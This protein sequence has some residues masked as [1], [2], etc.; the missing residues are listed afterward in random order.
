MD[1]FVF[2]CRSSS[3][4]RHEL[5]SEVACAAFSLDRLHPF[6]ILAIALL[7]WDDTSFGRGAPPATFASLI[8]WSYRPAGGGS[9]DPPTRARR[10][11][12]VREIEMAIPMTTSI[13]KKITIIFTISMT[14][15]VG[16]IKIA[17]K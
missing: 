5:G 17:I 9:G 16:A 12:V 13:R 10:A 2:S 1:I 15:F 14:Y 8:A 7:T 3:I 4:S 11:A 6:L